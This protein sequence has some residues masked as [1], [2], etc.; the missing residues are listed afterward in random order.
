MKTETALFAKVFQNAT[1]ACNCTLL[2]P[3]PT[4]N[5]QN[6][7]TDSLEF[8]TDSLIFDINS[9][10]FDTLSTEK[11]MFFSP[12]YLILIEPI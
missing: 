12:Y 8:D 7:D 5:S 2:Q 9:L 1:T 4:S 3:L 11:T 6:F 10:K